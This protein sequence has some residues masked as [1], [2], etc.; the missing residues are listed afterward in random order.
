MQSWELERIPHL[1]QRAFSALV[2]SMTQA[3]M[4]SRQP[5]GLPSRSP[6]DFAALRW[7]ELGCDATALQEITL[8][9]NAMFHLTLTPPAPEQPTAQLSQAGL[10]RWREGARPVT[11][12]TSGS[13]GQPKPCTH[14]EDDLRQ[15]ITSLAPLVAQCR[16]ALVTPP[17]HHMYG[18]TFGLLL[19]LALDIPLR[20]VPPLPTVVAAQMRP[21]DM[22]VGIPLLWARLVDCGLW[23]EGAQPGQG[24]TIFTATSPI[25]ATVL[26]RL[27]DRGFRTLEFFGASEMGV[28]CCRE[29]PDLPFR[30]LPHIQRADEGHSETAVQRRLPD[31][32]C[33]L[34]PLL[35]TVDWAGPREMVPRKRLDKAVQVAGVNVYP[36]HIRD[37]IE[38]HQGVRQCLVR[39]MRPEEGYRL[40]AFVVP[41]PGWDAACL[42]RELTALCKRRLKDV[43]RPAS[44]A[45]GA[46]IPRGPLGKPKD[47]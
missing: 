23:A 2:Q 27:R 34:Y 1:G 33:V 19:P 28:M 40:K 47:W 43:Q 38:E 30:L 4:G 8:L 24:V 39:L 37:I 6:Q 5:L 35:D 7:E 41:A 25:E 45:F 16:T 32:Q 29:N 44:Y 9:F 12:F 17:L 13:T 22:V 31:G 14:R 36:E 42:R 10:S 15:E 18:F 3:V 21:G 46:D 11:F 20:C 26:H